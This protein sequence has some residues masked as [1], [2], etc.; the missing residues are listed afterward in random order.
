MKAA[1]AEVLKDN[2]Y[3]LD[4]RVDGEQA[5][6]V[7]TIVLKYKGK[8]PVIDGIQRVSKPSRRVY[9]GSRDI[10]RVLDGLGIAVLSTSK[11][12]MSDRQARRENI[13]GEVLCYLW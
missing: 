7:L 10:P 9:V 2:G 3:I 11:G 4:Y 12:I 5:K 1:V 8:T 13:G 6:K